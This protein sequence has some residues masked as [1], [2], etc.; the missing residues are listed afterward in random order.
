MGTNRMAVP[1]LQKCEQLQH[2]QA[3]L[4]SAGEGIC[5]L[6]REGNCTFVNRT[7]MRMRQPPHALTV[8]EVVA[9]LE[10]VR[11]GVAQW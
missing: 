11:A 1:G 7:A 6:D 9:I 10:S 2:W 3:L 5:G 4:D 8:R